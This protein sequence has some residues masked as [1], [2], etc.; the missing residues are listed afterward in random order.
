MLQL[1]P[2]AG[3]LAAATSI[4]LLVMLHAVGEPPPRRRAVLLACLLLAGYCQFFADS[5][6]VAAG[7]LALQ[8]AL[9]IY[10][11]VR[12]RLTE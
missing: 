5:T 4:V 8:T 6:A 2:F 9:A 11:I 12:W 7:G 10:L 1:F 3:W